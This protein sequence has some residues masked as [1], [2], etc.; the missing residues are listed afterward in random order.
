LELLRETIRYAM[1]ETSFYAHHFLG[2]TTELRGLDDFRRLPLL[3]K[4]TVRSRWAEFVRRGAVPEYLRL[5]GGTTFDPALAPQ[6][7][8]RLSSD[9]ERSTLLALREAVWDNPDCL[10]PLEL[11]LTT[12][13]HGLDFPGAIKGVFSVPL[14]RP[15][16]FAAIIALLEHEHSFAGYSNRIQILSGSLTALQPLA[17]LCQ[18]RGIDATAFGVRS[19][20]SIGWTL[21]PRWA[22]LLRLTWGASTGE[23]YGVS[24]VPG[25]YALRCQT[26]KYYHPSPL[27]IT[28]VLSLDNDE[29]VSL[30]PGHL[31]VS[32]LHPL[33]RTFPMIRYKTEDVVEVVDARCPESSAIAFEFLG[34][35]LKVVT[36][37]REGSS[38][39]LLAPRHLCLALD[40]LP[41]VAFEHHFRSTNLGLRSHFGWRKYQLL[42]AGDRARP[43]LELQVELC[44]PP[45]QFLSAAKELQHTIRERLF[46]QSPALAEAVQSGRSE[47]MI[48]LFPPHTRAFA[49]KA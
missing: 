20:L 8:F 49:E 31:V 43:S 13:E 4:S 1:S 27:C 42:A 48:S 34:R 46:Q 47:L 14:E 24:E 3:D 23:L 11:R 40:E 18:E 36:I 2:C 29:Q 30:G 35:R 16:H 38:R 45:E 28:E 22:E 37:D 9:L 7:L 15:A 33:A 6:P 5:T 44:W 12:A 25:C 39:V 41:D 32:A 21:S 26:C 10:K 17:L 19:I